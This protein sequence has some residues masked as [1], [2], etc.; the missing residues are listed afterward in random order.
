MQEQFPSTAD[1]IYE[2]QSRVEYSTLG[3]LGQLKIVSIMNFL[4]D[5]AS[6]HASAMGMSGFDLSAKDLAWV[7]TNYHVDILDHP[8]WQDSLTIKT[9]RSSWKNLYEIRRFLILNPSGSVLVQARAAWVMVRKDTGRPVRLSRFN[10][11]AAEN[12]DTEDHTSLVQE[13]LPVDRI[14]LELPFKIRMQDLD[15]NRHV[16]NAVY[17]GWAAETVPP[18]FLDNYRPAAIDVSF[19]RESF[20]GGAVLSRTC[21]G[22]EAGSPRTSH[23]IVHESTQTELSRI[24]IDWQRLNLEF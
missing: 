24:I 4:Q 16:N 22:E 9:W 19:R 18:S 6:D 20:Y 21:I 11:K 15:L 10:P 14:D 17:V 13:L 12:T 5:A 23:S 3:S 2:K 1:R 8:R 7:I